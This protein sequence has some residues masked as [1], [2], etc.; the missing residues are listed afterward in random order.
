[1]TVEKF[2]RKYQ[3][4]V[5]EDAGSVLSEEFKQFARDFKLM[6]YEAAGNI[7][8]KLYSF[9]RGHY[10]VSGFVERNGKYAYFTFSCPRYLRIDLTRSDCM[11][12]FLVRTAKGPKD[13]TGG[14][15]NFTNADGFQTLL[16]ACL[17]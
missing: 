14:P 17:K 3:G 16:G 7:E 1:M 5:L 2:V 12:G 9:N 13:Y 8:A 10:D 11:S 15:N 6:A 4:R